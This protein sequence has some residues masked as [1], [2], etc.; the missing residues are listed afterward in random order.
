MKKVLIYILPIIILII[1]GCYKTKNTMPIGNDAVLSYPARVLYNSATSGINYWNNALLTFSDMS[2][3]SDTVRVSINLP[4]AQ[5]GPVSVTLGADQAAYDAYAANPVYKTEY[6]FM[7][8][9]YYK[10]VNPTITIPA[11]VTDTT[12]KIAF[13]PGLMDISKTGYLLPLSITSADGITVHESMKT[14][15]LHVER[16]PNPPLPRT[17]WEI[18]SVSSEE[19]TGEG[20]NNG[21]AIFILDG[22]KN[23]FWH[24]RWQGGNDPLPYTIVIDMKEQNV[25]KGFI[26]NPRAGGNQG[27]PSNITISGSNNGTSWTEISK[28]TLANN[29]SEQKFTL[30][31]PT[32]AYR[33]LK[34]VITAVYG[35][36]SYSHL[37]EFKPF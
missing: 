8:A 22:N 5:N 6:A 2:K 26:F 23:S 37:A 11:G 12:V 20:P 7:P 13:Y 16:D 14:A 1:S 24:S 19:A 15:Y 9:N 34:V 17:G 32:T 27:K 3:A 36:V 18:V 28:H 25:I 31:S 4:A 10:I 29:D 21:R 30:G 33:Y 35:G